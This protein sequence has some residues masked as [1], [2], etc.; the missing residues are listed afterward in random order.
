MNVENPPSVGEPVIDLAHEADFRLGALF[1][2]PSAREVV[3]D[4]K[5]ELLEP[6]VM[7]VLV[8][9]YR[10]Q[11]AV[12]S[13][14]TLIARCWEG[15]IVGEDAISRAIWRLR[16]L[17]EAHG[18]F[19][20]E[21]IPRIGYR[22]HCDGA[23]AS[24]VEAGETVPP[25]NFASKSR[26]RWWNW[27][28]AIGLALLLL[29][30][31]AAWLLWPSPRPAGISVAVLP[32]VN[33]S[34]DTS[35]EFLS[36]GI[37]E[38]ITAALAKI[39]QLPV[40]GRTSAF[41]YKGRADDVRAIGRALNAA[42]L[43]E[44]SVRKAG[45]RIRITAQLVSTRTGDHVWTDSYDRNLEDIFAVQEDVAQAIAGALQ[46]PLGLRQGEKLVSD[47][48]SDTN[49][50]QD[51]LRARALFRAR[52]MVQA[53]PLLER[54]VARDPDY[55]P[56]WAMLARAYVPASGAA[57]SIYDGSI[58]Q[59]SIHFGGYAAKADHA[60]RQALRLDSSNAA[61][62]AALA[63]YAI[64]R[65]DW[66]TGRVE[67][68]RALALDPNDPDTLAQYASALL[69][70]LGYTRQEFGIRQKI[71]SLEPFVPVYHR[72]MAITL[73]NLGQTKAAI[74]LLQQI[75]P[76]APAVRNLLVF[77]LSAAGR[78]GEAAD[79]LMMPLSPGSQ[80]QMLPADREIAIHLLRSAPNSAGP[81]KDLPDLP[82][83]NFVYLFVGAPDRAMADPER[84]LAI[85]GSPRPVFHRIWS[86]AYAPARK[87]ERFRAFVRKAGMVDYW[88]A[89]GWPD[90]CRPVGRDD[91]ACD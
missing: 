81:P 38:E 47:R 35:Q 43:L 36:D 48:T 80:P 13:R 54:T 29:A 85:Q 33:L 34:G 27:R 70:L 1:V 51:Y 44:G 11:G 77:A 60:A 66:E 72:E 41:Q 53:V 20:V 19:A 61:A 89:H 84:E 8:A 52:D 69:G 14:D 21:T 87:T 73:L 22:L 28:T 23:G 79:L 59:A 39:P 40:V 2:S 75:P 67:F 58:E 82:G 78:F 74:D 9:L 4:G 10:T 18:D 37:T 50:Y 90:I 17:A 45:D 7:Q 57:R 76:G 25:Y 32:F 86:P 63:Q 64:Y 83:L 49:S 55:A 3:R 26:S 71:Q 56:A 91:F 12:V 24:Q 16:K 15:R 5:H 88:R 6:R 30:A 68:N 65:H 62:H 46:V 42:Y 31:S